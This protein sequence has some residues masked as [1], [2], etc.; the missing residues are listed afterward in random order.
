MCRLLS[1]P[2]QG[3]GSNGRSLSLPLMCSLLGSTINSMLRVFAI[4][5]FTLLTNVSGKDV[6]KLED[7]SGGRVLELGRTRVL[8]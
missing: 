7:R 8:S 2:S 1:G 4:L 5:S 3:S 6:K